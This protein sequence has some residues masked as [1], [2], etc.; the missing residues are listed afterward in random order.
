MLRGKVSLLVSS[1]SQCEL[2][3]LDA[4]KLLQELRWCLTSRQ[5]HSG[6]VEAGRDIADMEAG[7]SR[8]KD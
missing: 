8:I 4:L 6:D 1:V 2:I 7:K 5:E 3:S